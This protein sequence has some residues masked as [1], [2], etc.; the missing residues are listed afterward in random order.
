[1]RVM[2]IIVVLTIVAFATNQ[3]WLGLLI[4]LF[5]VGCALFGVVE[6]VV[7]LARGTS[8]LTAEGRRRNRI[9]YLQSQPSNFNPCYYN[10]R[11][12]GKSHEECLRRGEP[13]LR[14]DDYYEKKIERSMEEY[15]N[16]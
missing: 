12:R 8:D 16:V 1:M 3:K 13:P 6:T 5:I 11:R 7:D 2:L 15:P 14:P 10:L 4:L 9:K